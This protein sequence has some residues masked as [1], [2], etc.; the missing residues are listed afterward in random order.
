MAWSKPVSGNH[1]DLL[2][3]ENQVNTMVDQLKESS[4]SVEG[5]FINADSGFDAEVLRKT[6]DK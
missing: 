1:T 4:I 2:Q 5:L 3:I 6:S